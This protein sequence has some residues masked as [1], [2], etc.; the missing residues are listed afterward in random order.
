MLIGI[1]E[2]LSLSTGVVVKEMELFSDTLS[3]DTLKPNRYFLRTLSALLNSTHFE[4]PAVAFHNM[5][6][7][8][9][10]NF[11]KINLN[12]T[13]RAFCFLYLQANIDAHEFKKPHLLFL[14]QHN[15]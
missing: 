10:I 7:M 4:T 6:P 9:T 2:V 5:K 1:E 8:F 3:L 14:L 11:L 12:D 13:S 15:K